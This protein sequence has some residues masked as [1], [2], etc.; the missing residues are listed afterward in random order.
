MK[1]ILVLY[2]TKHGQSKKIAQTLAD[3][4]STL[5]VQVSLLDVSDF[6]KHALSLDT[7]DYLV[8]GASIY[9]GNI[10]KDMTVFI[11][12]NADTIASLPRSFFLVAMAAATKDDGRREKS[13][14]EIRLN[15][16]RRVQVNFPDI[17]VFAGAIKY[18]QY[19]WLVKWMMKRI[20]RKEGGSVDTSRDYEYTD[21][22][23][24]AAYAQRLANKVN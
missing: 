9:I 2:A 21:W 5:G 17:E 24:L 14:A 13:L 20:A 15:L 22:T 4:L 19:N 12:K 1:K 18:T 23:Q 6:D 11:N 16:S 7:F 3:H 8:F 10:E